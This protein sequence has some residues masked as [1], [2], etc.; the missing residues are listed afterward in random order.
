[1]IFAK[2]NRFD[3]ASVVVHDKGNYGGFY[4]NAKDACGNGL[5]GFADCFSYLRQAVAFLKDNGFEME[6]EN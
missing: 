2:G 3:G 1:M 6:G 5:D 4:L